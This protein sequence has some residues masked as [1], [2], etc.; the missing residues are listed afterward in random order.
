M[1]LSE[2]PRYQ[3]KPPP[4]GGDYPK[5]SICRTCDQEITKRSP[6]SPWLAEGETHKVKARDHDHKPAD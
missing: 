2:V 6:V 4:T 1:A 5:H 3:A